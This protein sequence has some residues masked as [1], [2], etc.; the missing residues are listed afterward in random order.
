M[1]TLGDYKQ[2][3]AAHMLE[4][5]RGNALLAGE[6]P[7][8]PDLEEKWEQISPE[9]LAEAVPQFNQYPEVVFAWAAYLGTAVAKLWDENWELGSKISYYDLRG[10]HFDYL[11]EYVTTVIMGFPLDSDQAN[12]LR[13]KMRLLST[14]AYGFLRH[15]SLEPGSADAFKAVLS[16]IQFMYIL[17]AYIHLHAL[18]Y[19]W[20][21]A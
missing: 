14:E 9:F 3:L 4:V 1:D 12:V 20:A 11:D 10:A 13:D 7:H 18:G 2:R 19:K 8:T 16:T 17:G 21:E 15:S 6:L 5:C